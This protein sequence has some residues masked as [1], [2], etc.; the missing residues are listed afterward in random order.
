[1]DSLPLLLLLLI[2]S[3]CFSGLEI[4]LFSLGPEKIKALR[5]KTKNPKQRQ[6]LKSLAAL[7]KD[8]LE[9]A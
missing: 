4:A 7:K 3:A 9:V 1:M 5:D 8:E 2:L 6:R